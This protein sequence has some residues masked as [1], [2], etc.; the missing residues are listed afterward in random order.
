MRW[1]ISGEKPILLDSSEIKSVS[2]HNRASMVTKYMNIPITTVTACCGSGYMTYPIE[3]TGEMIAVRKN[4][5]GRIAEGAEPYA[6][7]TMGRSMEGYGIEENSVV[8]INPAEEA[9]TGHIVLIIIDEKA[10]VKKLYERSDGIDLVSSQGSKLH[11]TFE[12]LDDPY[13]IRIM[14]RVIL[15]IPPPTPPNEGV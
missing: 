10:S 7:Q 15:V 8:I 5:V 9:H 4:Q 3:F 6:V 13:Y 2:V 14:G 12:E 11:V 1:L